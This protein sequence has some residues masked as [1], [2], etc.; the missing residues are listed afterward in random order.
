MQ[1]TVSFNS[2]SGKN[3]VI[4]AI[5]FGLAFACCPLFFLVPILADG[6][7]PIFILILLPF[8][9]IGLGF[10]GYAVMLSVSRARVGTPE[11]TIS[12]KTPRVGEAFNVNLVHT[13][14][15][16]VQ[17]NQIKVQLI[18]RETATY[19]QGTDTKTVIHNETVENYEIPGGQY[20]SGQFL[21]QSYEMQ[22]PPDGMHTVKV[23]RNSLQWIVRVEIDIPKMPDYVDEYELMVQSELA[24]STDY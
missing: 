11:V 5:I 6:G 16:N 13:F 8:V 23:R 20:R 3:R 19:Q 9:L 7:E 2:L 18:F 4:F 14:K 15:R 24:P 21:Q 17:V 12:N 22:I 1:K 10:V